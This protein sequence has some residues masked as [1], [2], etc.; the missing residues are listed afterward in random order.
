MTFVALRFDLRKR[1][2][3][4]GGTDSGTPPPHLLYPLHRSMLAR[5]IA[6]RD[7]A[8]PA[9]ADIGKSVGRRRVGRNIEAPVV[10]TA[11]EAMDCGKMGC[12]HSEQGASHLT[13]TSRPGND[14]G[15]QFAD[16]AL[17]EC[18]NEPSRVS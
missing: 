18:R 11:P 4:R 10:R 3:G 6:A 5:N 2:M 1:A 15:D 7:E 16:R 9:A 13:D 17:L 14:G 8:D 12:I